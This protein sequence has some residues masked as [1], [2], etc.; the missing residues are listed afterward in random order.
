MG[1]HTAGWFLLAGFLAAM[2]GINPSLS[3]NVLSDPN[4]LTDKKKVQQKINSIQRHKKVLLA[5]IAL[6]IPAIFQG[7]YLLGS[8]Y[9]IDFTKADPN[10]LGR[11]AARGRGRGGIVLLIIQFFPYFLI[12]GYGWMAKWLIDDYRTE[13]GRIKSLQTIYS[14]LSDR[15]ADEIEALKYGLSSTMAKHKVGN[16]EHFAGSIIETIKERKEVKKVTP[17]KQMPTQAKQEQK[18]FAQDVNLR[19]QPLAQ[20]SVPEIKKAAPNEESGKE[21]PEEVDALEKELKK[22]DQLKQRGLISEEEY[23]ALRKKALGL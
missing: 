10:T 17:E 19:T 1:V 3:P 11:Q 7:I 14:Y 20:K 2:I 15:T 16:P 6:Q 23:Q 4:D 21:K 12:G 13:N 22:A 18:T 8:G 9:D 5:V